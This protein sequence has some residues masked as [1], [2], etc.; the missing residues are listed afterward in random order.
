MVVSNKNILICYQPLFL[1]L[2][3]AFYQPNLSEGNSCTL[4]ASCQQQTQQTHT[5]QG[6]RFWLRHSRQNLVHSEAANTI[7]ANNVGELE[8]GASVGFDGQSPGAALQLLSDT[9]QQRGIIFIR[10]EIPSEEC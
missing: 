8:C 4:T 10:Y 6:I 5:Q 1:F 2:H 9:R 3:S 7:G